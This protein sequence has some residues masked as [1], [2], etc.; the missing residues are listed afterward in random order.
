MHSVDASTFTL[1]AQKLEETGRDIGSM[2]PSS[3]EF[4]LFSANPQIITG[5]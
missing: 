1:A 4:I 2:G 5:F 3:E